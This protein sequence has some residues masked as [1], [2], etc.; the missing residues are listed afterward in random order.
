[1]RKGCTDLEPFFAEEEEG[2]RGAWAFRRSPELETCINL[3]PSS[4]PGSLVKL[5][6]I[7]ANEQANKASLRIQLPRLATGLLVPTATHVTSIQCR[8][9]AP[10]PPHSATWCGL[11]LF[12]DLTSGMFAAGLVHGHGRGERPADVLL[13]AARHDSCKLL[14]MHWYCVH[15]LGCFQFQLVLTI[16]NN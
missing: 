9:N 15:R 7:R 5:T 3:P 8:N 11:W 12:N 2:A 1:M 16:I 4:L 13:F 14:C 6:R 10:Q